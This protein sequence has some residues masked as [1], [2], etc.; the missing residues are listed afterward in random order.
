[1]TKNTS[2]NVTTKAKG[3]DG[4]PIGG[5]KS[6]ALKSKALKSKAIVATKKAPRRRKAPVVTQPWTLREDHQIVNERNLGRAT[7]LIA[8]DLNTTAAAVANRYRVLMR[9]GMTAHRNWA[10]H[11]AHV[12]DDAPGSPEY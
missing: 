2:T 4:H 10:A 3:S 8:K 6:K 9:P 12:N 5:R 1:M 7:H 11:A